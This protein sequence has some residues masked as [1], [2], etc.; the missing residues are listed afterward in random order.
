ML[1]RASLSCGEH[2]C[3]NTSGKVSNMNSS[4]M[5]NIYRRKCKLRRLPADRRTAY[6]HC[7]V[8]EGMNLHTVALGRRQRAVSVCAQAWWCTFS[9]QKYIWKGTRSLK[10]QKKNNSSTQVICQPAAPKMVR[11]LCPLVFCY[12]SH[13]KSS[14]QALSCMPSLKGWHVF[15]SGPLV[16]TGGEL[17]AARYWEE[18]H[19]I[20][21]GTVV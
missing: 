10:L 17:Q 18:N 16:Q 8:G 13:R 7:C 9:A 20:K 12:N 5:L 21:S 15:I 4:S 14:A 2:G 19:V 11:S 3:Q 1:N 6:I